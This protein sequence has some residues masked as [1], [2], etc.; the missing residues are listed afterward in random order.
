MSPGDVFEWSNAPSWKNPTDMGPVY[1][2]ETVSFV[3][4][5]F[6]R[7]RLFILPILGSPEN[8]ED[9]N[10]RKV[11]CL[12]MQIRT[13]DANSRFNV[14]LSNDETET[15]QFQRVQLWEPLEYVQMLI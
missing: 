6:I 10:L 12:W 8:V 7:Y 1:S 11:H 2:F 5:N 14:F 15:S 9:W 3:M 13:T 4:K